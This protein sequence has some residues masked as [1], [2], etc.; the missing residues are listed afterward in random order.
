M[1][2]WDPQR[3]SIP[4]IM[5]ANAIDLRYIDAFPSYRAYDI[6]ATTGYASI[7]NNLRDIIQTIF[8]ADGIQAGVTMR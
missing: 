8:P 5:Q 1:L 6:P 2:I 7:Y 3:D 4:I